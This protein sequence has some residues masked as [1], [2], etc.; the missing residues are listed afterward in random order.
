MPATTEFEWMIETMRTSFQ[1]RQ[2]KLDGFYQQFKRRKDA[3]WCE[4][5]A[6][7]VLNVAAQN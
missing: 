5:C 7:V 4:P 6:N 1:T 3:R 2:E